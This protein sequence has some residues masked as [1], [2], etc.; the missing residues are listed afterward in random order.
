MNKKITTGIVFLSLAA[1]SITAI[2]MGPL[3][4]PIGP[5]ESTSPSLADIELL[6]QSQIDGP[7][8]GPWQVAVF[9]SRDGLGSQNTS[10]QIAAG[11][12]VVLHSINTL[13]ANAYAFDGP[14]ILS[15]QGTISSG[16]VVGQAS[17]TASLGS[18]ENVSFNSSQAVCNV[19]CP[20][21]LEIAWSYDSSAAYF[22]HVYYKVLD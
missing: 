16:N 12:P 6:I 2:A 21:G 4:P 17:S 19:L 20:N 5:V 1:A 3:D 9:D 13:R 11:Q 8:V 18:S 7:T 10:I 15:G 14:G 22:V